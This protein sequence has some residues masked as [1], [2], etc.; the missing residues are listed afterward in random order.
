MDVGQLFPWLIGGVIAQRL[1]ELG[2]AR[3]NAR[4]I[5]ARGGFEVGREHYPWIVL[6]H[7][8]FFA[9]MVAEVRIRGLAGFSVWWP[10]LALFAASQGLRYWSLRSLGHY[11]NTRIFVIPGHPPV[12]RGPYRWLKHPNYLAVM[13]E[14]VSLPLAFH[15]HWTALLVSVAN[16]PLLALRIRVEEGA[17]RHPARTR[18]EVRG[19]MQG[20][21]SSLKTSTSPAEENERTG[22]ESPAAPATS[23]AQSLSATSSP[24]V[25]TASEHSGETT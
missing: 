18:L 14:L 12:R 6:L 9:G 13:V 2:L 20:G 22:D 5:R 17:L 16:A 10:A 19:E 23:V 7:V 21:P 25:A 24:P 4:W 11:W 3:H 1:A 8:S 15:A